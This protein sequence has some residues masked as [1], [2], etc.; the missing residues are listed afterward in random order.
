[1][2][3]GPA[4][5]V[6]IIS[7]QAM[8][9]CPTKSLVPDGPDIC[10]GLALLDASGNPSNSFAWYEDIMVVVS[11][12]NTGSEEIITP[13]GFKD[14]DFHLDLWFTDPAGNL[15]RADAF[16]GLPDP[17]PPLLIGNEQLERVERVPGTDPGPPWQ[18]SVGLDAADPSVVGFNLRAYYGNLFQPGD[19]TVKVRFPLSTYSQSAVQEIRGVEYAPIVTTDWSGSLV[20]ATLQFSLVEGGGKP[21]ALKMHYTGGDCAT[22]DFLMDPSFF[23]CT[24]SGTLPASGSGTTLYITSADKKNL[25][26]AKI[27]LD[28]YPLTLNGSLSSFWIDAANV[29]GATRLG[30]QTYVWI[31]DENGR[32]LLQTVLFHSSGSEPLYYGDQFGSLKLVGFK[33]ELK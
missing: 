2:L 27:W 31:R 28:N 15:I 3:I 8:A 20:S 13:A 33:P 10:V 22:S 29:V 7:G 16:G 6:G 4:I 17:P 1:M 9:Q 19:Y 25:K 5:M 26:K 21:R 24:D 11:L 23:T 12:E 14:R 30:G 18:I 32:T